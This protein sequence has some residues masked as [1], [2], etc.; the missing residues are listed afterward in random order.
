[1]ENLTLFRMQVACYYHA[2]QDM[3]AD[4]TKSVGTEVLP[5]EDW[6]PACENDVE[7]WDVFMEDDG[8]GGYEKIHRCPNCKA[9]AIQHQGGCA[10]FILFSVFYYGSILAALAISEDE[11]VRVILL[12]GG[13]FL[14]LLFVAGVFWVNKKLIY[15]KRRRAKKPIDPFDSTH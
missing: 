2:E 14:G 10:A 4:L 12:I 8:E 1:M 3:P 15:R 9:K 5:D 13:C 7:E 6:C 11:T